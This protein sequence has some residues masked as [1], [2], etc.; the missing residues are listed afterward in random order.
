M[1]SREKKKFQQT[2]DRELQDYHRKRSELLEIF[3]DGHVPSEETL[4][5]KK[6]AL[7]TEQN[8]KNELYQQAKTE[9]D[10]L[11]YCRQTLEDYRHNELAA[12]RK[13]AEALE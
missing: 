7:M 10:E 5:R 2:H 4:E 8:E 12:E 3:P 13:K 1:T 11:N 9:S 6:S